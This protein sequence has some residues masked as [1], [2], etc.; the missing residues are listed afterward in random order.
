MFETFLDLPV[1]ILVIHA[2]VVGVPAAALATVAV[3]LI[4]SLRV[5][6]AWPVVLLN[7]LLLGVTYVAR[8]SGLWFYGTF[9]QL[10][11]AAAEHRALGLTLIWFVLGLLG[12]SV[13]LALVSRG[14]GL[15]IG[16]VAVVVLAAAGAATVQTIRT[17]HAGSKAV[18]K[19]VVQN[20]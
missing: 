15:V 8:Q 5:R 7:A 9:D 14:P 10:P 17:G 20:K 16:L 12:A 19:G 6:L 4:P 18:W 13:L 2:V 11:P 1:H 3:A